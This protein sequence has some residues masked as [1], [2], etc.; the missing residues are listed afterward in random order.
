ML[1]TL[2]Q[3]RSAAGRDGHD[4][5]VRRYFVST[6][7]LFTVWVSAIV[8]GIGLTA[9]FQLRPT[10]AVSATSAAPPT[11]FP[12]S[13]ILTRASDQ[14]TLIMFL[15]PFCP[16]SRSS[17]TEMANLQS[18]FHGDFSAYIF[19]YASPHFTEPIEQTM[20]WQQAMSIPRVTVLSDQ[21]G[22]VARKFGAHT[23]G[24]VVV[25]DRTGQ[26][27]FSGGITRSRGEVGKN[28]GADAA[29]KCL[30]S[31]QHK[32]CSHSVYGCSLFK[33]SRTSQESFNESD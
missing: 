28:S 23:S 29:L 8:V 6:S 19:F 12:E 13:S 25:Y 26:L 15:H 1:T 31:R 14:P 32:L 9:D 18:E 10:P 33:A 2:S 17:L 30:N 5:Y 20:L 22:R 16:C 24:S 4:L 27:A 11:H 3:P 7:I 21:D